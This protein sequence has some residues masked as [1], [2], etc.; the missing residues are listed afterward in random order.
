MHHPPSQSNL[1]SHPCSCR[2]TSDPGSTIIASL[3][4]PAAVPAE[5]SAQT[6]PAAAHMAAPSFNAEPLESAFAPDSPPPRA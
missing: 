2:G 5:P 6:P 3:I 4:G 1:Q